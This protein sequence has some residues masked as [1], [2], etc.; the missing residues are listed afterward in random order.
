LRITTRRSIEVD[1]AKAGTEI[2][3]CNFVLTNRSVVVEAS[4]E[5]FDDTTMIL[6][7]LTLNCILIVLTA[8]L[9]KMH[10][11]IQTVEVRVDCVNLDDE[12]VDV[13]LGE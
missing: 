2:D 11:S 3:A 4:V 6:Q 12:D 7:E 10:L 8:L 13:L 1:H 9:L 5:L